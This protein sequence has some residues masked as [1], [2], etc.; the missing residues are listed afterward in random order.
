MQDLKNLL[1]GLPNKQRQAVPNVY[2]PG[3][4]NQQFPGME[5][6]PGATIDQIKEFI[7]KQK[8]AKGYP[9]NLTV[10]PNDLPFQISGT[11]QLLLGFSIIPTGA[12]VNA[13][14]PS[15]YPESVTLKINDEI[16][17][18]NVHG[19]Q[20]SPVNLKEEYYFFPRPLSGQD[21]TSWIIESSAARPVAIMLYYI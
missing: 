13:A 7:R 16:I 15:E 20:L 12:G 17:L 8:R 14:T 6:F 1:S 2:N 10:G 4:Q 19:Y 11:A 3:A 18:Q 5:I 21:S 9:Y